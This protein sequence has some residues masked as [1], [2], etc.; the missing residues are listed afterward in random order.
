MVHALN[1]AL[2]LCVCLSVLIGIHQDTKH[3]WH[4]KGQMYI[5]NPCFSLLQLFIFLYVK[6]RLVSGCLRFVLILLQEHLF[7]CGRVL[8]KLVRTLNKI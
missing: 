6:K 7:S 8:L 5:V 1:Y 4:H 3:Y 2:S